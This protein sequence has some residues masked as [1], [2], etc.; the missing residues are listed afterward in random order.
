MVDRFFRQRVA[1]ASRSSARSC[2]WAASDA[3]ERSCTYPNVSRV[4]HEPHSTLGDAARSGVVTERAA[5][6]QR[7][8]DIGELEWASRGQTSRV[9]EAS[10]AEHAF[11]LMSRRLEENGCH[12]WDATLDCHN[13]EGRWTSGASRAPAPPPLLFPTAKKQNRRCPVW[14]AAARRA[15]EGA[16]TPS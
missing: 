1:S 15:G 4:E 11:C 13:L 3:G 12:F 2:D 16:R 5:A 14:T 9:R 7:W 6:R 10:E 8:R